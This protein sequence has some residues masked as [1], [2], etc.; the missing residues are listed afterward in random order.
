MM[1]GWRERLLAAVDADGRSDRA[2]SLAAKLGPN[3]VNELRN[4][5]K[6]PG[7]KKVLQLANEL[8][9]SLSLLFLGSETT[10]E[11]EEFLALFR[12]ASDAEREGLL[13]LLRAR[14]ASRG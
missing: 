9:V 10:P 4:A 14:H 11:D 7:V 13:A 6:E 1:P 8:N 2:I 12:S 5:Q 3:F